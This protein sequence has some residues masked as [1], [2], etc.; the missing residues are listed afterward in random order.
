MELIK[1]IFVALSSLCIGMLFSGIDRKI[2]ARFQSRIGPPIIQAF[3]DFFKLM[4]KE[5]IVP[6]KSVKWLFNFAPV[7]GLVSS[8]LLILYLP[9]LGFEPVLRGEGDLIVVLY[10]LLMPALSMVIG[11]FASGNNYAT[12]GAQR[13]MIM[14]MS[15]EFPLAVLIIG[16]VWTINKISPGSA[17]FSFA[18]FSQFPLLSL[19]GVIGII[20]LLLLFFIVL[21]ALSAELVK[22]PFDA[23]EADTEL[24]GGLLVEY[25][26]RNLALFILSDAVKLCAFITLVIGLFLPHPLSSFLYLG[27]FA[28]IGDILF[29]LVKFFIISF[30][31]LTFIRVAFAR[32][33]IEQAARFFWLL[34]AGISL[35]GFLLV[36]ID[37]VI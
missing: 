1:I 24:A 12:V 20:G 8:L 32:L 18:T 13:K 5:T 35:M 6:E 36:Y 4:S 2:A 16:M 21:M 25:S 15:Y 17:S 11:G 3:R 31:G 34:S 23:P 19:V 26:G 22:G 28:V 37:S 14:M 9:F 29:F 33:K 10:L 27:Q 7:L 30:F